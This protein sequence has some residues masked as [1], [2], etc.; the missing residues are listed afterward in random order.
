MIVVTGAYGFI[1]SCLIGFLNDQG[2][3][4]IIAVDDFTKIEK[5]P[6]L[7]GKKIAQR[8]ERDL[9]VDRLTKNAPLSI[10]R[11][12]RGTPIFWKVLVK[13]LIPNS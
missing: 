8:V 12:L 5:E 4:D 13:F 7:V 11:I 1:G 9:F 6:N 10:T 3:T 2:I